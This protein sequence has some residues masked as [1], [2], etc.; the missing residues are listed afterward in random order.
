MRCR[1]AGAGPGSQP[2]SRP[3]FCPEKQEVNSKGRE[4]AGDR[5]KP[6]RTG[7][8]TRT[9]EGKQAKTSVKGKER[10][11]KCPGQEELRKVQNL[12]RKAQA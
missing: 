9:K 3:G 4:G 8:N 1:T 7:R 10:A 11:G 2:E 5:Q 6:G 12:T